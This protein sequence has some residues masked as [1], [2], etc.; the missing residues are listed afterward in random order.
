MKD[1]WQR[2]ADKYEKLTPEKVSEYLNTLAQ[3]KRLLQSVLESISE[4]IIVLDEEKKIVFMNGT[5]KEMLGITAKNS[6]GR[7]IS[8]YVSDPSLK[9]FFDDIGEYSESSFTADISLSIPRKMLLQID[10]YPCQMDTNRNGA[11]ISMNDVTAAK[12]RQ[13][14]AFQSEKLGALST[15]AAGVAHEIGNPL[16]SIGIHMQLMEKDI[17]N[18]KDAKAKRRLTQYVKSAK[19]EVSRLDK[20]IRT[21]LTAV[22]PASLNLTEHNVNHILENVLDFLYYEISDKNIAIEKNYSQKVPPIPLDEE[23][24][25]QAFFNIVKNA[26]EAMPNGGLLTVA[27]GADKGEI[28]MTFSDTGIGITDENLSKIFDPYFTTKQKGSGLGLMIVR[29]IVNDHGGRIEVESRVGKGT[30][31]RIFLPVNKWETK[32]LQDRTSKRKG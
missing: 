10:I 31:V 3:E 2:F 28:H 11:I 18:V 5:A 26:V 4:A 32:M 19:A 13:M 16:N 15:L 1:F 27:T 30:K 23:Q 12:K 9:H 14:D 29:K 21:F 8:K 25:R 22:R 24:I 17:K 20:M 7:P 6:T